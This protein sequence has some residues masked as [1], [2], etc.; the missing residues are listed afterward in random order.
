MHASQDTKHHA[1]QRRRRRV[2]R[3]TKIFL[4]QLPTKGLPVNNVTKSRQ[5]NRITNVC[6][7]LKFSLNDQSGHL[8]LPTYW[9]LH[10]IIEYCILIFQDTQYFL[11][12]VVFNAKLP[13]MTL[14]ISGLG[15]PHTDA[16]GKVICL[17]WGLLQI[18]FTDS[19][20]TRPR[21]YDLQKSQ[22]CYCKF[23]ACNLDSNDNHITK[24]ITHQCT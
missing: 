23:T 14:F 18:H 1:N 3:S 6:R 12:N 9:I 16:R 20:A 8:Q 10:L 15:M 19:T 13:H 21:S 11:F 17:H 7:L 2:Y 24:F 4:C 22:C 5:L